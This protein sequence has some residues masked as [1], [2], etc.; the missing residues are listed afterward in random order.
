MGFVRVIFWSVRD[1]IEPVFI[2]VR[3]PPCF[4]SNPGVNV[5]KQKINM[6][7][8]V[9]FCYGG[10]CRLLLLLPR[11]FVFYVISSSSLG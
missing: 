5:D 11:L 3:K 7:R 4:R 1:Y 6:Y 2:V 9:A 8:V 10:A